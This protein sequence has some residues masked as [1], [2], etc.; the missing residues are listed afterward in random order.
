MPDQDTT[1][2]RSRTTVRWSGELITRMS[3]EGSLFGDGVRLEVT[4][5][6]PS[7]SNLVR[8]YVDPSRPA[9]S[10]IFEFDSPGSTDREVAV[11]LTQTL[12]EVIP[13]DSIRKMM[14]G[15]GNDFIEQEE[16]DAFSIVNKWLDS[17]DVPEA[18]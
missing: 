18:P 13:F 15:F 12:S 9:V 17:L 7:G 6:L 11:E 16:S 4:N 10:V 5:G 1:S 2:A 14:G 3:T 8:A